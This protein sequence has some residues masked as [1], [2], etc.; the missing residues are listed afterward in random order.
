MK[1]ASISQI[2]QELKNRSSNELMEICLRLG[3]Y[4]KDNKELITYLLFEVQDEQ[5]Y[6]SS[7][8]EEM[9]QQFY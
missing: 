3:R 1:A 6:I 2:K 4:K 7:I 9:T 5:T 8:K